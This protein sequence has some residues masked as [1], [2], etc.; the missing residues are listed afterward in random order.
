M[1][2]MIARIPNEILNCC[3]PF[4]G[5]AERFEVLTVF[6]VRPG[7]FTEVCRITLKEGAALEDVRNDYIGE[8]TVLSSEGR[9]CTFVMKGRISAEISA[10]MAR[11]DLKIDYPIIFDSN[12]SQFG[13]LGTT[14]ELQNIVNAAKENDWEMEIVAIRDYNPLVKGLLNELTDKQCQILKTAYANGYFD[15]PRKIDAGKLAAKMGI[16]KTTLL[17][18]MHKAE[19]RLIGSILDEEC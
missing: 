11:F 5:V 9:D 3:A 16:H 4:A 6:N 19:K 13:L 2:K 7:A 17:E 18:H 8:I 12:T 14:E 1:R 15:H 10:F